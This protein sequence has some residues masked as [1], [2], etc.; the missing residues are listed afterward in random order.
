MMMDMSVD[1]PPLPENSISPST[2]ML[3]VAVREAGQY[4]LWLQFRGGTGLYV[5]EFTVNAS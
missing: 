5:A 1:P 4:K 2:M 3:H